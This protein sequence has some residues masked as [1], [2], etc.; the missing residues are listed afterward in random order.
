M[1]DDFYIL[2]HITKK[3][4]TRRCVASKSSK[5]LIALKFFSL[6]FAKFIQF[7]LNTKKTSRYNFSTLFLFLIFILLNIPN[8]QFL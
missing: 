2:L 4:T 5:I 3:R 6:S 7:F 8:N 1:F